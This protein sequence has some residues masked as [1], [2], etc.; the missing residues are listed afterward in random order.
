MPDGSHFAENLEQ[1][2]LLHAVAMW[3]SQDALGFRDGLRFAAPQAKR[4]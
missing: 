2:D 4:D 3:V 1:L